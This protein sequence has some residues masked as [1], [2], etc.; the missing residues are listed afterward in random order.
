MRDSQRTSRPG[1]PTTDGRRG[2]QTVLSYGAI[3]IL[4]SR[5][6]DRRA[7]AADVPSRL[8]F[9]IGPALHRGPRAVGWW[10]FSQLASAAALKARK[11][12]WSLE[13]GRNEVIWFDHVE[14]RMKSGSDRKS[15][16]E[17]RDAV[18]KQ[19]V[20]GGRSL[21]AVALELSNKMLA[22]WV[23]RHR[24]GQELVRRAGAARVGARG[25]AEPLAAGERQAQARE[26]NSKRGGSVLCARVDVK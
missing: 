19:V 5:V 22:N 14:G 25:R 10:P 12:N 6:R 20:E 21:S 24:N 23:C 11:L 8:H 9:A 13:N 1:R 2:C 17:V 26:E 7:R 4:A 18:I 3:G 16:A 15:T